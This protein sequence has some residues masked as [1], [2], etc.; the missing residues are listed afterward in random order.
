ML[1]AV[2]QQLGAML[3]QHFEERLAVEQAL[4]MFLR[5]DHGR[6]MNEDHAEDAFA[7]QAREQLREP[8]K[9]L[10]AEAPGGA[11]EWSRHRARKSDQGDWPAP[12]HKRK[13]TPSS[14]CGGGS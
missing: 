12:T 6:M 1:V 2:Q 9:L 11:K 5:L 14:A 10:G 4:V 8:C 7:A 13:Q 3:A